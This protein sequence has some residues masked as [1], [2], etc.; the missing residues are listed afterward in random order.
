MNVVIVIS[1]VAL[2][3]LA[4]LQAVILIGVTRALYE[5]R[6]EF[7]E[8]PSLRGRL[9]PQ[10]STVDLWGDT[11]SSES[12]AGTPTTMLFVSPDCSTCSVTLAELQPLVKDT[13]RGLVVVCSG[14]NDECRQLALD[15]GLTVPMVADEDGE[16]NGLFAVSGTPLAVRIS[17]NG[18]IESYGEP[19]RGEEFE[20]LIAEDI[21]LAASGPQPVEDD[22][23]TV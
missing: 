23:A 18:V 9:A 2:W 10:F 19:A 21:R 8:E 20:R 12:L 11:V 13:T 14:D 5:L 16:L 1:Y 7:A 17:A 3:I 22:K 6:D 4:L 15:Y